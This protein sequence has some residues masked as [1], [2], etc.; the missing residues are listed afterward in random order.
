MKGSTTRRRSIKTAKPG[1]FAA[2]MIYDKSL[3]SNRTE[4]EK[5]TKTTKNNFVTYSNHSYTSKKLTS[6]FNTYTFFS[7]KF[8]RGK[9]PLFIR[10][11]QIACLN[12]CCKTC[13]LT[14]RED[15]LSLTSISSPLPIRTR[16][17][18]TVAE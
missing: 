15:G 7:T 11:R 5:F 12:I 16:C 4:T 14:T 6:L 13:S 9:D 3:P 18:G 10:S 17:P 2:A 1:G 8:N